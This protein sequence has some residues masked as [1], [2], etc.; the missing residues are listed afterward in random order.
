MIIKKLLILM[1]VGLIT[2][3]TTNFNFVNSQA[4][5]TAPTTYHYSYR[6]S[7]VDIVSGNNWAIRNNGGST[8]SVLPLYTRT[9]GATTYNYYS[10]S[11]IISNFQID[12]TFNDSFSGWS[13]V[14]GSLY[15]PGNG[16]TYIGVY[17][18]SSY[19]V[20]QVEYNLRNYS[21]RDFLFYLD[22]SY[23]SNNAEYFYDI[24]YNGY[25]MEGMY[26]SILLAGTNNLNVVYVPAYTTVTIAKY[27]NNPS[28]ANEYFDAWYL[29]D[30]GVSFGYGEV[31]DIGYDD[32]Y[33]VGYA[34]GFPNG[35]DEGFIY[36]TN[37]PPMTSIFTSVFAG[38]A[39]IFNIGIFGGI[40]LGT[41]IIAPIAV[42]LLW[43]ILGIVSGVGGKK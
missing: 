25:D 40:T 32:G 15:R 6:N 17:N 30:L 21:N 36:A 24:E 12:M 8:V 42:S 3:G 20:P 22:R 4:L 33:D 16:S 1:G 7:N 29:R 5:L 23:V 18:N 28:Y 43:F 34:D 26:K 31:Y 19:S 27:G 14:S 35:Y 11:T 37:N 10:E 38:I 9:T 41:I 39:E 2:Y 13:L